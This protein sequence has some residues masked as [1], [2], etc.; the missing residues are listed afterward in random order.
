MRNKSKAEEK[1]KPWLDENGNPK[2]DKQLKE[3]SK[4]WS[5]STWEDYLRAFESESKE[6]L[7]EDPLEVENLS[8]Y[9]HE[10]FWKLVDR[11]KTKERSLKR[12]RDI[13]QIC[14]GEISPRERTVLRKIFWE[15]KSERN[16]AN[17]LG[18][19]CGSVNVFKKRGLS[20]IKYFIMTGRL[21]RRMQWM[22]CS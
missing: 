2:S 20:K 5:E 1:S 3:I 15:D 8:T 4:T 10:Y 19:S 12:L 11:D 13:I 9:D 22:E 7:L 16:I 18:I 17:E 6:S 14:L 21:H